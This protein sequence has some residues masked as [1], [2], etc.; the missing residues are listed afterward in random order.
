MKI[1]TNVGLTDKIVRIALAV[2]F[3]GLNL[4]GQV[5][6][7]LGVILWVLAGVL[8]LTSAV[9]FCPLYLPFKISTKGK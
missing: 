8:V 2:L 1:E 6:G 4:F 5:G 9:S 3:V 7:L